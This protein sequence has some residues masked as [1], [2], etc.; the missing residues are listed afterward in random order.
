MHIFISGAK[1][2]LT[3][4]VFVGKINSEIIGIEINPRFGGGYPLS[5][6]SG[7]NYPAF[8]I[9]EYMMNETKGRLEHRLTVFT[10]C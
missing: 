1:G 3:I 9:Q 2:C 6:A 4:Q 10:N 8:I 7:A 5:Y